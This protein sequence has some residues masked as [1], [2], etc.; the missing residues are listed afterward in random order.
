M[1]DK[2]TDK[3]HYTDHDVKNPEIKSNLLVKLFKQCVAISAAASYVALATQFNAYAGYLIASDVTS[4]QGFLIGAT[5]ITTAKIWKSVLA[6]PDLEN[7]NWLQFFGHGVGYG[8][9][10]AA[11]TFILPGEL[12][13][14]ITITAYAIFSKF[15]IYIFEEEIRE[16]IEKICDKLSLTKIFFRCLYTTLAAGAA[17][18]ATYLL[19]GKSVYYI[20]TIVAAGI[21]LKAVFAVGAAAILISRLWN[22]IAKVPFDKFC[23]N[24]DTSINYDHESLRILGYGA[25][26]YVTAH[27]LPGMA[28]TVLLINA[29]ALSSDFLLL[30]LFSN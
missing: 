28:G 25:A 9:G 10:F 20:G 4:L 29:I 12:T 5:I 3:F 16:G 30:K 26:F 13:S 2:L 8:L 21:P 11:S 23:R 7:C 1:I 24:Q 18:L 27:I 19:A 15:L 14:L 6:L 17:T 22:A